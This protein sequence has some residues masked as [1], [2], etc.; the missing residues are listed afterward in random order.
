MKHDLD[1][2]EERIIRAYAKKH[3]YYIRENRGVFVV[4]IAGQGDIIGFYSKEALNGYLKDIFYDATKDMIELCRE[5]AVKRF[6]RA[7]TEFIFKH[8]S[9]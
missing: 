2:T 5:L 3:A 8:E 4:G 1:E 6:S 9:Q 7:V